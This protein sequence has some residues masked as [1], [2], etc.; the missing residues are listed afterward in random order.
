MI[1]VADMSGAG[2]PAVCRIVL[3]DSGNAVS[4]SRRGRNICGDSNLG[5]MSAILWDC[6]FVAL[7][8]FPVFTE[9]ENTVSD[10][11]IPAPSGC[12]C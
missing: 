8:Q 1:Q 2:S 11:G 6:G 10:A 12:A 4:A 5:M 7:R 3:S 9:E